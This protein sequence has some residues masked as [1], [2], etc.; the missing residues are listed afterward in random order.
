MLVMMLKS[1]ESLKNTNN[2]LSSTQE[3]NSDEFDNNVAMA[4]LKQLSMNSYAIQIRTHQ[5]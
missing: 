2:N 1:Q 5:L 4:A 3:N